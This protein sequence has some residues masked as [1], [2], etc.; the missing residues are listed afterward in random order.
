M[1]MCVGHP[2]APADRS[3][4]VEVAH[5]KEVLVVCG[6]GVVDVV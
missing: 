2:E 4:Q 3:H 6:E 5:L 1:N